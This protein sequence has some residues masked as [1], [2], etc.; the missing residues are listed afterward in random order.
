VAPRVPFD[1]WDQFEMQELLEEVRQYRPSAL[2]A[3]PERLADDTSG[4]AA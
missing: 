3:L 4:G 2:R 1:F